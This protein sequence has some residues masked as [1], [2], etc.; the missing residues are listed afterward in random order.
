[1]ARA[2]APL[3]AWAIRT[4][5]ADLV[6]TLR[7]RLFGEDARVL[8]SGSAPAPSW[9]HAAYAALGLDLLEGYG[10]TECASLVALNS[11]ARRRVG[12]VGT[13]LPGNE[14]RIASDGEVLLRSR[15][16]A[17]ALDP[18]TARPLDED[19][20]MGTGDVGFVDEEGFLFLEGRKD[21]LFKT[22]TG[23]RI[24]PA[25]IEARL[26]ESGVVDQ[27]VVCGPFRPTLVA[28]VALDWSRL[29]VSPPSPGAAHPPDSDA[30]LLET[31]R[32]ILEREIDRVN[33]RGEHH[34]RVD[35]AL[36]LLRGFSAERAE[37]TSTLKVRRSAVLE[38]Q[39]RHVDSLY[40]ALGAARGDG[41][42]RPIIRLIEE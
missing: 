38:A 8:L 9:L 27:A 19:G 40:E 25:R 31:V 23:W 20:F 14:V 12:S 30:R 7:T 29:G 3:L 33:Q 35:G 15:G 4:C 5:A 6:R 11:V 18:A 41:T 17:R 39:R 1:L 32:P 26:T 37:V 16:L 28:I 34:E 10:L 24:A 36:V 22:S 13:P 2:G 21:D 42:R